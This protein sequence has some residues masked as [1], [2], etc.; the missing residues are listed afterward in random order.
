MMFPSLMPLPGLLLLLCVTTR[1][2][3]RARDPDVEDD[4]GGVRGWAQEMPGTPGMRHV[5][6]PHGHGHRGTPGPRRPPPG[7]PRESSAPSSRDAP[8]QPARTGNWC[9]FVN[10]RVVTMAVLCGTEN[11]TVKL[12]KP[13]PDGGSDCQTATYSLSSR[14]VYRQKQR[15]L[16]AIMWKCCPG[17]GGHDCQE[18]EPDTHI[19]DTSEV[20]VRSSEPAVA[21]VRE[22]DK[23]MT[24]LL[25][26]ED[27]EDRTVQSPSG[28]LVSTPHPNH[29]GTA[30]DEVPPPASLP[31]FDS[32]SLL[33]IHH[34]MA[35][36]MS[37]LRP[38]LDGFNQSIQHLSSQVEGLSRDLQQLKQG[39]EVHET[40]RGPDHRDPGVEERLESSFNQINQMRAQLS[41]QRDQLQQNLSDLKT[42]MEDKIRQ[43][44]IHTQV[45]VQALSESVEEVRLGQKRLEGEL[46]KA[47]TDSG[48]L[49]GSRPAPEASV[50]EAITRLDKEVSNTSSQLI[51]LARDS[52]NSSGT[53]K[54]LRIGLQNLEK[55]LEQVSQRSEVHFAETGLEVEAGKVMVLNR[56]S[57]LAAN[58]SAHEGQLREIDSELD[59]IYQQL[60]TK[61]ITAT[62]PAC[63]CWVLAA[64]VARIA[65]EVS[66]V[67]NLAKRNQLAL[68][69]AKAEQSL[70]RW[71]T[72][73]EDLHQGLLHVKESL[74]YEQEKTRTLYS[75]VSQIRALLLAG[76]QE[77]RGLKEKEDT[78]AFQIRGL[79]ASF[80]SL[81][82]DAIRHSDV[83][84][85]L[86]GEEVIEFTSWSPSEQ[87]EFSIP[88]LLEKIRLMQEQIESHEASIASLRTGDSTQDHMIGDDPAAFPEWTLANDPDT[89]D[90]TNQD[91][92]SDPTTGEGDEDYSVSDF[93]SLG[94]E[95]EELAERI[96]K[97]EGQCNNCTA[98]SAAPSDSL[99]ELREEIRS[100]NQRLEDHLRMFQSVFSHTEGLATSTRSLNLDQLWTMVKKKEGKRR[101]GRLSPDE[102]EERGREPSNM[103]SKRS[104]GRDTLVAFSTN[105]LNG[106]PQRSKVT[107]RKVSMNHGGAYSPSTGEFHAPEAGLYLF[108]VTLNFER[109]PS[110]AVLSRGDAPVAS[111]RERRGEQGGPVSGVFL[112]ELQKG[113]RVTLELVQGSLRQGKFEKNTFSGLLL[114]PTEVDRET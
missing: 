99:G 2:D 32:T 111:L 21:G 33:S 105:L 109:G 92:L 35:A 81:L 114:V 15:V 110:L 10:H 56:V 87:G 20:P 17:H 85:V 73:V 67:T 112:L 29:T 106:I 45:S 9:A 52:K 78:K 36:M 104:T 97:L 74:A 30:D 26:D 19:S 95:V 77:I 58:V 38:V 65:L 49:S 96:S 3:L 22:S 90:A 48:S 46:Q 83:L 82:N 107:H 44:H 12:V 53:I 28:P 39:Q 50:L 69:D 91:P 89:S 84:E 55:R 80:S 24:D 1:C 102:N 7:E 68:E 79:S 72:E 11:Y 98:A 13:C 47:H 27:W 88:A 4:S 25:E 63:N 14:P 8:H 40:N 66:N 103:R 34:M 43:S 54:D 71:T 59:Y 37:Q 94:R 101:K 5:P 108:L 23:M 113:E 18:N 31:F 62:E 86:L 16:T 93:W 70:G 6:V 64:T 75:N 76:Q 51:N 42:E 41:T 57:E 61:N 100:L 60:Q